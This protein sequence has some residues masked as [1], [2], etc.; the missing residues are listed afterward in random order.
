[1]IGALSEARAGHSPAAT[2]LWTG[3][4]G[5]AILCRLRF[6]AWFFSLSVGAVY[7]AV[8]SNNKQNDVIDGV[9]GGTRDA[10][11]YRPQSGRALAFDR[12]TYCSN[13]RHCQPLRCPSPVRYLPEAHGIAARRKHCAK[14]DAASAAER[15]AHCVVSPKSNA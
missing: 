6:L 4:C 5:T 2:L 9:Q 10:N 7:T 14:P 13:R 1:M 15:W 12:C 11:D 8:L 3:H